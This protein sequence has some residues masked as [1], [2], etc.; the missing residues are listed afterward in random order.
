MSY[1]KNRLS[2]LSILAS[3]LGL[4]LVVACSDSND[5][6]DPAGGGGSAT[7]G[8]AG[9]EGTGGSSDPASGGAG[10]GA[11]GGNGAGGHG[12]GGNAAGG[13]AGTGATPEVPP[14]YAIITQTGVNPDYTSYVGVTDS[15]DRPETLELGD[16][17]EVV[18]RAFGAGIPG[19]G[20]VFVGGNASG[21]ITR[22]DLEG[23]RL[24]EGPSV[25]FDGVGTTSIGE[26]AAQVQIISDTRAYYFDGRVPQVVVWN[27]DEMVI[28][29]TVSLAALAEPDTVLSFTSTAP[30]RTGDLLIMPAGWRVG[31]DTIPDFAGVVVVDTTTDAVT[32][33]RHDGRC[34]YVRDAV[35]GADGLVYI[36]TEAFGS[37]AWRLNTERA[38]EPCLLRFDPNTK[39]FDADYDVKLSSLVEGGVAGS[40]AASASGTAYV[41]VLDPTFSVPVDMVPRALASAP[42]WSWYEME[43]GDTPRATRVADAPAFM[44][45][46][47]LLDAGDRRLIPRFDAQAA[48]TTFIDLGEGF[49]EPGLTVPGNVF[50]LVR[51]R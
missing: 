6:A 37:A 23:E 32:V 24:M 43:L 9:V 3:A 49:A 25:S 46:I 12:A 27:P 11:T 28:D 20:K 47:L 2:W 50:S 8:G 4:H 15:L 5:G 22:Y 17:A 41:R 38:S 26:Y 33:V 45:S 10:G 7:G 51:L 36:A 35:V 42:A 14:L 48:T 40:L 29:D 30:A 34:G 31:T 1:E 13:A 39:S 19:S 16:A 18:G 44:G 21:K